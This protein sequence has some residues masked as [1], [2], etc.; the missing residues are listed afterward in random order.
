MGYN[1]HACMEER[2]RGLNV[3]SLDLVAEGRGQIGGRRGVGVR[4]RQCG[5]YRCGYEHARKILL[6]NPRAREGEG[7]KMGSQ[8]GGMEG[9]GSIRWTGGRWRKG[10]VD[11]DG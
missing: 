9:D 7:N 3:R 8:V 2:D 6:G 5:V 11:R 1:W 10:E 4:I